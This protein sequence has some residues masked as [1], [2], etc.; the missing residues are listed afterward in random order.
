MSYRKKRKSGGFADTRFY[1]HMNHPANYR[2]IGNDFVEYIT[3]THHDVVEIDGKKYITIPLSDNIEKKVRMKNKG[4][5]DR[6]I[7]FVYPKVYVGR[8]SSLG[9]ENKS[10]SFTPS[11]AKKVNELFET[12]PRENVRY[13]SNSR[14]AKKKWQ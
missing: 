13:T 6:D 14:K 3:L 12:L 10:Y 9:R 8:R 11:D 7:S 4:K 2:N 5:K 1:P